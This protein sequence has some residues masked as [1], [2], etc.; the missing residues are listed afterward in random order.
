M[1]D[2]FKVAAIFAA[3]FIAG[4]I[5]EYLLMSKQIKM[6]RDASDKNHDLYRKEVDRGNELVEENE[7]LVLELGQCR[8]TNWQVA[9]YATQLKK[10]LDH[11]ME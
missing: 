9:T 11:F 2:F 7:R 10:Q 6:E 4:D 3:G 8:I 1:K 5:A